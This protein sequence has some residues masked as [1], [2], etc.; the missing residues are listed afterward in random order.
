MKRAQNVHAYVNAGFL[1]N[2]VNGRVVSA[3]LCYGGISGSFTHAV[4]TE[5]VLYDQDL[6]TNNTL[7]IALFSLSEE[8]IPDNSQDNIF[9]EYRKNLAIAL[10]Y[11]FVLSFCPE[12]LLTPTH[13][14][15]A[16]EIERPVSSGS[17]TFQTDRSEWPLTEPVVKYEGL[18][19]CSGE[20]KYI[21]DM[22]KLKDELWAA[23]V[24]AHK[25]QCKIDLI[26]A[27][28]ALVNATP[29]FRK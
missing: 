3:R 24:L 21:N 14:S 4:Q 20:A 9:P 11:K 13:I 7:Q 12:S 22:P 19:Q 29:H 23:F 5:A 10:F 6:Y 17:Q 16:V 18:A 8:L 2:I 28:E 25:V 15:G 1:L 27:T 26:D